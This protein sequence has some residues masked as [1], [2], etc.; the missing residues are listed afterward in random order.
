MSSLAGRRISDDLRY[1]LVEAARSAETSNRPRALL[2]LATIIFLAAGVA[3]V[4][5]LQERD[6]AVRRFRT[7]SDRVA[8]V[9][10]MKWQFAALA[11]REAQ[12][13]DRNVPIPD[14]LSRM[15]QA[16]TEAGL[17]AK[18][19]IP[20]DRAT[21]EGGARRRT[22]VYRLTDPSLEALL[23]W[24][25]AAKRLVPG[26]EVSALEIAPEAKAWRFKV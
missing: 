13:D 18:P 11:R 2:V 25:E 23:S 7:Q 12:S 8:Q 20:E 1:E 9:E 21:I 4:V 3:L 10:N 19:P 15:E 14:L 17:R 16:A 26:L 6:V 22:V 24:V 5:T